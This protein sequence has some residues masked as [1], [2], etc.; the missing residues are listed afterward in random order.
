MN[1]L[2]HFENSSIVVQWDQVANVS[3]YTVTLTS[4]S[5]PTRSHTLIKQSPYTITG[6]TLDA[7]YNISIAASNSHCTGP[8]YKTSVLFSAGTYIQFPVDAVCMYIHMQ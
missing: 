6:L 3:N 7:V 2:K 5:I 8:E 4:E 1:V